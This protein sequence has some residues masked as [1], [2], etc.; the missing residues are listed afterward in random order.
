[1]GWLSLSFFLA[2][3]MF[4]TFVVRVKFLQSV[5]ETDLSVDHILVGYTCFKRSMDVRYPVCEAAA[6]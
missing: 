3:Q 1:M 5:S 2:F 6:K 4:G